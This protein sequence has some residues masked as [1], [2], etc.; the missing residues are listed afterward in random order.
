MLH[1]R[2]IRA[3]GSRFLSSNDRS[4]SRLQG[5]KRTSHSS[6]DPTEGAGHCLYCSVIYL[7]CIAKKIKTY[8]V[9]LTLQVFK[10]VVHQRPGTLPKEAR[11]KQDFDRASKAAVTGRSGGRN[12]ESRP[13]QPS[14]HHDSQS[15]AMIWRGEAQIFLHQGGSRGSLRIADR[16]IARMFEPSPYHLNRRIAPVRRLKSTQRVSSV[17]IAGRMAKSPAGTVARHPVRNASIGSIPAARRAGIAAASNAA[18]PSTSVASNSM[19]GSHALTP[20]S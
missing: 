8:S 17:L 11:G 5:S 4:L 13:S 19:I 1:A 9:R 10:P 3:A 15:K 7:Y 18:K 14:S 20:K 6:S 12:Y 16:T 2:R